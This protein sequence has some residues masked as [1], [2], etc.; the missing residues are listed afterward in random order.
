MVEG[1]VDPKALEKQLVENPEL[2]RN[3]I[4][5]NPALL[6]YVFSDAEIRR[7]YVKILPQTEEELK[8]IAEQTGIAEGILLGLGVAL[9][10]WLIF[11]KK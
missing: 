5:Q 6:D 11:G 4:I 9:L 8:Q 7:K 3:T 1:M 2:L 10:L